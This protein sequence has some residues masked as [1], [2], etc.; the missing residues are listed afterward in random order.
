MIFLASCQQEKKVDYAL[1]SGVI[2]NHKDEKAFVLF[3]GE[4]KQLSVDENGHFQDTIKGLTDY[5]YLRYGRSGVE[6]YI[7]PNYNLSI[8]FD[9][10]EFMSTLH[11]SGEGAENNNYLHE[12]RKLE[13]SLDK[14][15]GPSGEEFENL[16][17]MS[18]EQFLGF[19]DKKRKAL[20]ELLE[21]NNDLS[22]GF[23]VLENEN[24]KFSYLLELQKYPDYHKYVANKPE[25][26]PADKEFDKLTDIG[27]YLTSEWFLKLSS[28][29]GLVSEYYWE[30]IVNSE[31][32]SPKKY[33]DEVINSEASDKFKGL[34]ASKLGYYLPI[35]GAYKHDFFKGV[36]ALASDKNFKK[37]FEEKYEKTKLLEKGKASPVF[38][39]YENFNGET[40]SLEDFKGKYVYIDVWATWCGPCKK[41]IPFLDK[42]MDTYEK[43]NITFVSIS[44]DPSEWRKLSEEKSRE[45]WKKMV[46][47]KQMRG[48]QLF[49]SKG[50]KS[51]FAKNYGIDGIPRFILIDPNGNIVSADAPR[52]SDPKLIELFKS[53]EI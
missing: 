48:V 20:S 32:K 51:D 45:N 27:Q 22:D 41:E 37:D 34:L 21:V 4:T 7:V 6:M 52:P 36:M 13:E 1:L 14:E 49:S 28:C 30:K 16:Y 53:L 26:I 11:Y 3:N 23:K 9:G 33:F 17:G 15:L 8:S 29:R 10:K 40:S 18:E 43:N 5:A 19:Q 31:D 12:K 2:K 39:D 47:E 38:N 24:L 42:I 44:V 50:M 46:G 25:F 35:D